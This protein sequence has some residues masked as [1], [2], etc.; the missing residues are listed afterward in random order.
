MGELSID[1]PTRENISILLANDHKVKVGGVDCDGLLRGKVMDKDKFLSSIEEGFGFS[2]VLFGWDM[3]DL[4]YTTESKTTFIQE[5]YGDFVATPDIASFRR[6]PW[7]DNIPFFLLRFSVNNVPVAADGRN[8]I[9]SLCDKVGRAGF[10]S[11]A[12]GRL[13]QSEWSM[14]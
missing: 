1:I 12:G 8:M 10:Q 9:R 11:M 6:L 3:H 7:E 13:H 4:L 5:G 14:G 2:S